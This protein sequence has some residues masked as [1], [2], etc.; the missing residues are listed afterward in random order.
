MKDLAERLGRSEVAVKLYMHRHNICLPSDIARNMLK[1]ILSLRMVDP[2][3]WKPQKD[4]FRKIKISQKRYW[5]IY[6]GEVKMT[7][8]EYKRF[9][10]FFKL[11]ME[12]AFEMRQLTLQLFNE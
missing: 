11:T 3:C 8:D 7:D 1:E 2:D 12:E 5:S 6:R 4:F 10:L 9:A